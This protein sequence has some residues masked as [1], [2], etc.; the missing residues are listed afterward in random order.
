MC[1]VRPWIADN[2]GVTFSRSLN[3]GI[4][5]EFGYTGLACGLIG[6]ADGSDGA[7]LYRTKSALRFKRFKSAD[8]R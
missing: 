8:V 4:P 2:N 7:V 1:V 5:T 6:T 3:L